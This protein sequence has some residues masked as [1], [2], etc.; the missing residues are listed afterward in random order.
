MMAESGLAAATKLLYDNT[1]Y[2]NYITAMP[3]PVPAP[4]TIRTEIYRPVDPPPSPS[5]AAADYLRLD[6]AVGEILASRVD[7]SPTPTP[8][9]TPQVDPRP[10]ATPIPS[11]TPGGSFGL[12]EV[13]PSPSVADSFDFNQIVRVGTNNTGR[14]VNPDLR[15]AFGQWIRVRNPAGELI[16]RYAFFIEDESMKANADVSGNN[17]GGGA[18]PNYR[19]NDLVSPALIPPP[20]SQ[21]HE[22]DPSATLPASADRARADNLL[23]AVGAAGTR[24]TSAPSLAMLDEW[25]THFPDIAHLLTVNSKNSITTARGWKR[26][27]LNEVVAA[28]PDSATAAQK[29]ADWIRDAWTGPVPLADFQEDAD[30]R[31]YQLFD[32]ERLRKQIAAS[33]VDYIDADNLPTD[34]GNVV[35][36]PGL[37]AIPVI[38]VERIPQLV[39]VMVIYQAKER[40]PSGGTSPHTSAKMSMKLRFNFI[41]LFDSPVDLQMK[42]AGPGSPPLFSRIEVQGIPVITKLSEVVFDKSTVLYPIPIATLRAA[43]GT[44]SDIP[45][46]QDGLSGSGCRSFE[47]NWLETDVPVQFKTG[48]GNPHF[49]P[50]G[51]MTVSIFGPSNARLDVT[52]MTWLDT[53]PTGY[54]QAGAPPGGS[55]DSSGDFLMDTDTGGAPPP[56]IPGVARQIAAIFTQKS[57]VPNGPTSTLT[58]EFSDPRY[59]P[60]ILNEKWRCENR[61]DTESAFSPGSA[62]AVRLDQVDMLPKTAGC[63]WYNNINNRPLAFIRNAP[64]HG[65]G[66]LGFVSVSEY[67]W[68]TLYFQHPDRPVSSASAIVSD[69]VATKR[70]MGSMDWVLVD[71]FKTSAEDTRSGGININ[72]ALSGSGDFRVLD[73][74]FLGLPIG[75]PAPSPA[76]TPPASAAP[77]PQ[78]LTSDKIRRLTTNSGSTTVSPIADHRSP[79]VTTVDNNPSRPFFQ[80]G[81]A[82]PVLSRLFSLNGSGTATVSYSALRS[83]P[84]ASGETNANYRSDLQVEQ[85]FR[86]VSN[87]ITTHGD[88]FRI[89]YVGQ[90]IR[91][92]SHNGVRNGVVDGPEEISAEYFGEAFV[93]RQAIF[94]APS[95]PPGASPNPNAMATSD[96]T[97]KILTNRV[98]TE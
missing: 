54:R 43:Q 74:L 91:D 2:G 16:G 10:S 9:P 88:V 95:P 15:P 14:L 20:A 6:N 55:S 40:A 11:P 27:S 87:S 67:P 28:G 39:A 83:T 78:T 5:P 94:A 38:G 65:I 62:L 34:L 47:T 64:M 48:S 3:A 66:E 97:Y 23:A 70:R 44:G 24:L 12:L 71:L 50:V 46:G 76:A 72:T 81:Q 89:L 59:R 68:R 30:G 21:I 77:T 69:E 31:N 90:S 52:A 98:I 29:I 8:N 18:S 79:S 7:A 4:P 37:P 33:I 51:Q 56:T 32:D 1:K 25:K 60:N 19:P 86:E 85:A 41:N 75:N 26:M 73:A 13:S 22:I 45:P 80:I 92:I 57:V 53:Q 93:G 96:S 61:S 58:R 63:D 82:A 84:T 49:S 17:L 36:E 35:P 42:S